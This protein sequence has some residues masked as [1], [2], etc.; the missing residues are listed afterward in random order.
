MMDIKMTANAV[1]SLILLIIYVNFF[2]LQSVQKYLH[3]AVIIVEEEVLNDQIP[4]PGNNGNMEKV[5][6]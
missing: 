1:V 3:G 5:K 4:P 6:H 2:G